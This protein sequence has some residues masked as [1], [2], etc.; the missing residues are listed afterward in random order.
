MFRNI[1]KNPLLHHFFELYILQGFIFIYKMEL[2]EFDINKC[3]E[4]KKILNKNEICRKIYKE[5]CSYSRFIG[6]C[7]YLYTKLKP[8]SYEDFYNKELSYA[9]NNKKLKIE[10][11]GLT[12]KEFYDL[13]NKYKTLVENETDIKLELSTYFYGLVCHAIIETF[14]GQQKEEQIIKLL[15]KRGFKPHKVEGWKDARYG[16][17]I[18]TEGISEDFYIQIKPI[19]FF[20]SKFNDT[21]QDRLNCCIKRKELLDIE[22]IETYYAIYKLYDTTGELKWLFN[23]NDDLLFNNQDLFSWNG[24]ELEVTN[25]SKY[26]AKTIS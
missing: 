6:N 12:Y 9:E 20:T 4:S 10:K 15:R 14:N 24:D 8:E 19:T 2:F 5:E 23:N 26:I 7:S 17:D 25:L 22:K 3:I 11:R 21:V 13:A 18:A 1:I 16:V